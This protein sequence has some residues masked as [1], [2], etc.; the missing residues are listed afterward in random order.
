MSC[1]DGTTFVDVTDPE[2]P[3]VVG[4]VETAST[5]VNYWRDVKVFQR[6]SSQGED[7]AAAYIV[8]DDVSRHCV[9]IFDLR[10]L[11]R[12]E[13]A[14]P[15]AAPPRILEADRTLCDLP[16]APGVTGLGSTTT[17]TSSPSSSAPWSSRGS[18]TTVEL[19]TCHNAMAHSENGRVY[20][21]GC[22]SA[23]GE[24]VCGG[25][26]L[27]T[28]D[29]SED[30]LSPTVIG[31][32]APSSGGKGYVHDVQCVLEDGRE[33]CYVSEA[34]T[35]FSIVD[36]TDAR[37]PV[38]LGFLDRVAG[39]VFVHQ[40]WLSDDAKTFWV[41]DELDELQNKGARRT[42]A[43]DVS[44]PRAPTLAG[45]HS[46][47]AGLPKPFALDHNLYVRGA[48]MVQANYMA[49]LEV[50]RVIG[51]SGIDDGTEP[52]P[53][54]TLERVAAFDTSPSS[55]TTGDAAR[56]YDGAWSAYHFFK[57]PT[58]V[59][60]AD[61]SEGLIVVRVPSL[62]SLS[63]STTTTTT[64]TS[65]DGSCVLSAWSAWGE[66]L[67]S[68]S[69]PRATALRSS[70]PLRQQP[71]ESSIM[72]CTGEGCVWA[73]ERFAEDDGD[74]EEVANLARIAGGRGAAA[75]ARAPERGGGANRTRGCAA[76]VPSA[77]LQRRDEQRVGLALRRN[78]VDYGSVYVPVVFHILT[79][80][81]GEGDVPRSYIDDQIDVLNAAFS[82]AEDARA[83]SSGIT[84]ALQEVK[85]VAND[86][87]FYGCYSAYK[88]IAAE[89]NP[90]PSG[91]ELLVY[92][93]L[94]KDGILGWTNFP[95]VFP[96]LDPSHGVW[97]RYETLPG[98]NFTPFH[99]GKTLVHEVGHWCGGYHTFEGRSCEG[100]GDKV[101]D[102][103]SE[104]QPTFGGA[105]A[106]RA[107]DTCADGGGFSADG[108]DPVENYLDY[109]DDEV[110]T[111]FTIDQIKRFHQELSLYRPRLRE[112]EHPC[113]G[114][115]IRRRAVLAGACRGETLVEAKCCKAATA[116][117][118]APSQAAPPLLSG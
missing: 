98:F 77:R 68:R 14:A 10:R 5:E 21:M 84:F 87:Y 34:T 28:L 107:K 115:S 22:K 112:N 70:P 54:P 109:S 18:S 99:L 90:K 26:G 36:N 56:G 57:D 88:E 7:V 24:R 16:V 49:G 93:C 3:L 46:A 13:G 61:I 101:W 43:I 100:A 66:C 79:S 75:A 105:E 78:A 86:D 62:A 50:F 33:L 89:L 74:R 76:P 111:R 39:Q 1:T 96:E 106:N 23:S 80:S 67:T 83:K 35:G 69:R 92:T 55:P 4:R 20:L 12:L 73:T 95:F 104:A 59:A 108:P 19:S 85:K 48:G 118:D 9:Q 37:A 44:N 29:V 8:A 113:R 6:C 52:L 41:G 82:G 11:R 31:C 91:R 27:I 65:G 110:M 30:A 2:A 102:T 64:T 114:T 15:G 94:P 47:A 42:F 116:R 53:S 40:G 60:V 38:R 51:R 81:S 45:V 103:P 117:G 63:R 71:E 72:R 32:Y 17:T 97:L 25:G 58:V